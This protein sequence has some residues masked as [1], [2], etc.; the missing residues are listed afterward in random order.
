MNG[1]TTHVLDTSRGKPAG[2][3]PVALEVRSDDGGWRESRAAPTDGDGRA[4]APRLEVAGAARRLP[5]LVR[6]RRLLPRVR[7]SRASIPRCG[8]SSRCGTSR[9]T[10]TCRSCSRRSDTRPT[11]GAEGPA[12]MLGREPYGKSGIRLVRSRAGADRHEVQDLTVAVR[13]EGEFGA[14]HVARRQRRHPSD[15]HDEEH[16]VRARGRARARADRGLRA[17]PRP[18]LRLDPRAAWRARESR[19]SSTPWERLETGGRPHRR[20]SPSAAARRGSRSRRAGRGARTR[21]RPASTDLVD[22]EDRALGVRRV[23]PGTA[24]RRSARRTTG[25]SRRRC[26]PF[27]LRGGRRRVFAPCAR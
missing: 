1:I 4:S 13:L 2:G 21:S 23:P 6:H 27:G 24:T 5:H 11:G 16:R 8:S 12:A 22:P 25:S 9:R 26:G 10:I 7:T 15:G 19:S 18:A 20:L 17:R 14:A 3:V